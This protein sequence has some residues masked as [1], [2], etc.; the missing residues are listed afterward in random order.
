MFDTLPYPEYRHEVR[1]QRAMSEGEPPSHRGI[2]SFDDNY[3]SEL[4]PTIEACWSMNPLQRPSVGRILEQ[5]VAAQQRTLED[6]YTSAQPRMTKLGWPQRRLVGVG[7]PVDEQEL[8]QVTPLPE[9]FPWFPWFRVLRSFVAPTWLANALVFLKYYIPRRLMPVVQFPAP[10]LVQNHAQSRLQVRSRN[11]WALFVLLLV[12]HMTLDYATRM[13]R[14]TGPVEADM[15]QA[16][17][18]AP[19]HLE[20][21]EVVTVGV[22][23]L[24]VCEVEI[25]AMERAQPPS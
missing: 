18:G 21:H 20:S 12:I 1:I 7:V 24:S 16:S 17:W 14:Y 9:R 8:Q 23:S 25:G 19:M 2:Y 11:K 13:R 4:W 10:P 5:A 3:G 15:Y 22:N 6:D